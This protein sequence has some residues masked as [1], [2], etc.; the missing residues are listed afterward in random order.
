M[1]ERETTPTANTDDVRSDRV[2]ED[3]ENGNKVSV[4]ANSEHSNFEDGPLSDEVKLDTQIGCFDDEDGS[5]KRKHDDDENSI[6]AAPAKKK[7]NVKQGHSTGDEVDVLEAQKAEEEEGIGKS[8]S[9]LSMTGNR[10]IS[11]FGFPSVGVSNSEQGVNDEIECPAV[12]IGRLIGKQ[13]ETIKSLQGETNTKLQV[14]HKGQGNMKKVVITGPDM[15]SISKAKDLINRVLDSD[16]GGIIPGEITEMVDCPQGIVGRVIGRHGETIR[17]L[18]AASGA[19]IVVE[20]NFPEGVPRKV[21]ISGKP[22]VVD[23][24]VKMVTE[25]ISGEPGSAIGVIN[26]VK[27]FTFTFL[28]L[29]LTFF[30][31]QLWRLQ[32]AW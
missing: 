1:D 3:L 25:L 7:S 21:K 19:K 22:D 27:I 29:F 15:D 20:Q 13:G 9:P 18:Q 12:L 28:T 14:D 26:K 8:S 4:D 23:L 32:V 11:K 10:G 6:D 5:H 31:I 16:S 17:S 30:S 24:A 2:D